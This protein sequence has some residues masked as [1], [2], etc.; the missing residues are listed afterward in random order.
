MIS[1]IKSQILSEITPSDKE[2]KEISNLT[3]ML[4]DHL[5]QKISKMGLNAT[6]EIVGSISKDT[7][8]AN[9]RDIDVFIVFDKSYPIDELKK[10]GL[11]I[12]K[13]ELEG[14][15][16]ET[17]Y[18]NHPYTINHFKEFK[19][20]VVPCY[21]S[22]E[23]I[24]PVD[25]TPHHTRFVKENI[26]DLRNEVRLLKQFMK[27]VGVYSSEQKIQGFSGY[28]CELLIINYRSFDNVLKN[29]SNWQY[30][31]YIDIKKAG[32]R[33]DFTDPLIVI[34]PVDPKRNVASALSIE[35][36][37]EFIYY[38]RKYIESPS[39]EYF[40]KKKRLFVKRFPDSE[41]YSIVFQGELLDDIIYP[42]LR[43]TA[44]HMITLL[45]KHDF[46]PLSYGL[47]KKG[48]A[49]GIVFEIESYNLSPLVKHYGPKIFDRAHSDSFVSKYNEIF[50]EGDRSYTLRPRQFSNPLYV[51]ISA[52]KEKEGLGKNLKSMSYSI[53]KGE[54]ALNYL[55]SEEFEIYI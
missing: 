26:G 48:E 14:F 18:A 47:F 8:I 31:E 51:L 40:R 15:T 21:D 22:I 49:S 42:Q 28:L 4:V 23:I 43:K 34:D 7:W 19:I 50:I 9:D 25:R 16:S 52:I 54:K 6:V 37:C 13:I 38:A 44:K 29:A 36:L 35:R 30:G 10:L 3:N 17:A 24:T 5:S 27:G 53:L 39:I 45:E 55:S 11:V 2:R 41:V 33:S 20:D 32:K 1:E 12:G 46:K